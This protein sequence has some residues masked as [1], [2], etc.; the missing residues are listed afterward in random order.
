MPGFNRDRRR[1]HPH[2]TRRDTAAPFRPPPLIGRR[3]IAIARK[4]GG[5]GGVALIDRSLDAAIKAFGL[6][7]VHAMRFVLDCLGP[8]GHGQEKDGQGEQ[9]THR[10][11]LP[12]RDLRGA[13]CSGGLRARFGVRSAR[14]AGQVK[15]ARALGDDRRHQRLAGDIDCGPAHVQD[16]VDREQ[17]ARPLERQPQSG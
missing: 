7:A 5:A 9:W 14:E 8:R 17:Q 16:R 13:E 10:R 3:R 4:L 15:D 11:R 6:R 12:R 2:L 1:S